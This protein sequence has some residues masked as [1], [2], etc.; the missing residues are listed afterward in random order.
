MPRVRPTTAC[1]A[2]LLLLAAGGCDTISSDFGS[3]FESFNPPTPAQAALWA[4]DTNDPENQRRGIA[5]LAG[6][7][8]GGAE[9]YV[10][11]YRLYVEEQTDPLV[12]AFS[13]RALGRHGDATDAKL[14]AGQ[15]ASTNRLIRLEAARALQRLH[16]PAVA[17]AIW[18]VL[19]DEAEDDRIRVELAIALG[20]YR[21][22]SVFQALVRTLDQRELAVNLAALDSLQTM[23][24]RDFGLDRAAW[25]AWRDTQGGQFLAGER[26][27]Y[28]T[29]VRD[30]RFMDYI[31]FWIPVTFEPPGVPVGTPGSGP[32][33]TY[34]GDELPPE[35]FRVPERATPDAAPAEPTGG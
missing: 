26:Y 6:A 11:L 3:L 30:L 29:F 5:L 17:D 31:L 9:P 32:R 12:K 10:R 23:T 22:D 7:P 13:I 14:V 8:W 2:A 34:Q 19:V 18:K 15:L 33:R 25:L 4:A 24:G 1:A 35:E 27:L 16:D 28:P 21:T 20:Q